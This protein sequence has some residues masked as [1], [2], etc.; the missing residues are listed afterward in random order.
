MTLKLMVNE[1]LLDRVKAYCLSFRRTLSRLH[2]AYRTGDGYK[3]GWTVGSKSAVDLGF[4]RNRDH[5]V[6]CQLDVM[7]S[8]LTITMNFQIG[9]SV[10][11]ASMAPLRHPD[12]TLFAFTLSM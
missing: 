3:V 11:C 9:N 5:V 7:E 8:T 10:L 6:H 4:A 2:V 12:P 1:A